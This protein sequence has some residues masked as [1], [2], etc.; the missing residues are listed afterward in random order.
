M[1]IRSLA[2]VFSLVDDATILRW[3]QMHAGISGHNE[4]CS[5]A[6][7]LARTGN[8]DEAIISIL[9]WYEEQ[10]QRLM[11]TVNEHVSVLSPSKR[12]VWNTTYNAWAVSSLVDTQALRMA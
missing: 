4:I 9:M 8:M 5:T 2:Q 10:I 1:L 3:E 6:R 11:E 7:Q 12:H